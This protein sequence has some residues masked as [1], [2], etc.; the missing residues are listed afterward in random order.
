MGTFINTRRTDFKGKRGRNYVDKS[1]LIAYINSTLDEENR[2]TCVTRPRRFGKTMAASMLQA[3]YDK[4]I[5]SR[6]LF[7]DLE[8]ARISPELPNLNKYLVLSFSVSKFL[9]LANIPKNPGNADQVV[10]SIQAALLEDLHKEFPQ[11]P[12]PANGDILK[13]LYEIT[14]ETGD[15]FIMIIDEW[16]CIL[17]EITDTKVQQSYVTFLRSFFKTVETRAV[18]AA[19]YMTG[20]LPIVK[21]NDDS[22]L[23]DF[24]EYTVLNPMGLE[25]Y[26]GFTTDEVRQL[27]VSTGRNFDDVKK[28]YDGYIVGSEKNIF[29]PNSVIRAVTS[30]YYQSYWT[31]NRSFES[32]RDYISMD[33]D[34][35][36]DAVL[37]MLS[38][39]RAFVDVSLFK[40]NL[41]NIESRNDV[42]TVLILLG[43]LSY[44]PDASEAFVPNLEVSMELANAVKTS[45]YGGITEVLSNSIP[46]LKDTIAMKEES[47]AAALEK[48][49]DENSSVLSYNNEESLACAILLA[50]SAARSYYHIHREYPT[51]KGFADIVLIPFKNVSRPAIIFEL[52]CDHSPEDAIAQIKER[53]YPRKVSEYTQD[54]ILVGINYDRATKKHSCRIE[55]W[56]GD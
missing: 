40:N 37:G 24:W 20:I 25:K 10:D 30:G 31:T 1:G 51:G 8:I 22:V 16:D 26:F 7:Q 17:R 50:Y 47:V 54:I 53:E 34:G 28:W 27:C 13:L 36:K 2:F 19:V 48:A 6:E 35:L 23:N 41:A 18:F 12:I 45:N 32:I 44:D 9:A 15:Q 11:L 38:G 42:L 55:K 46:L 5:S 33:F 29:N 3:Y 14:Q 4:S 43:Y 56:A 39:E 21:I 49:H 52:K